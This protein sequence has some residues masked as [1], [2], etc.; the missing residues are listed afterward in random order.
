M[1]IRTWLRESLEGGADERTGLTTRTP[2][3]PD[4][5]IT[6]A[7]QPSTLQWRIDAMTILHHV[8]SAERRLSASIRVNKI[9]MLAAA[10]ELQAATMDATT[11]LTANPCPEAGLGA[12]VAWVLNSCGEAVLTAQ[13][14]ACDP[15]AYT[16]DTIVRIRG[17]LAAVDYHSG[18]LDACN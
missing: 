16:E 3:P 18:A 10:D 15:L 12:Q 11:W 1:E 8:T 2:V 9:T 13:R 4:L 17:L 14:A 5:L 7:R 6:M